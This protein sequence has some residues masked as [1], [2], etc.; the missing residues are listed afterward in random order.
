MEL[1]KYDQKDNVSTYIHKG[2][3]FSVTSEA[4]HDALFMYGIDVF[5][6]VEKSI[7]RLIQVSNDPA[8]FSV[9]LKISREIIS[10]NNITYSISVVKK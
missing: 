5:T 10:D 7:D 3:S 2:V 9:R 1:L 4:V 8:E 6:I